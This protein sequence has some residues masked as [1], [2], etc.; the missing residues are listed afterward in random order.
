MRSLLALLLG[1][2]CVQADWT[3]IERSSFAP[4]GFEKV[5]RRAV[6]SNYTLIQPGTSGVAAMQLV[7]VSE[8]QAVIV[9]RVENNPLQYNRKPAWAAL[10]GLETHVARALGIITNSFCAGGGFLGNGTLADIGGSVPSGDPA[11]PISGW[12]GMRLF[13]PSSCPDSA[14]SG[15]CSFYESP[16]RIRL[17]I[18]RWYPGAVKLDDGSIMA[19]GGSKFGDYINNANYAQNSIEYF[20]AK[21]VKGSAGLPIDSKFLKDAMN[22]NLFPM[23]ALLP[24]G[25]VFVVANT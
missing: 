2:I 24:D 9:D 7:I 3:I 21:N 12:Q 25:R 17:A 13:N 5:A 11:D 4:P 18:P 10:Y 6:P 1:A 23:A 20:P 16:E 19:L 8:T 14:V 22:A 15:K